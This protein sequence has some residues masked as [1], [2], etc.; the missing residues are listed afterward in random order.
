MGMYT[1]RHEQ[2]LIYMPI[3]IG[4]SKISAF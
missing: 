1:K 4:R 3:G 2:M